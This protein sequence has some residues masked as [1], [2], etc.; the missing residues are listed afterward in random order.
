MQ[1]VNPLRNHTRIR[2]VLVIAVLLSFS[3]SQASPPDCRWNT[4]DVP[5]NG[6]SAS[7]PKCQGAPICDGNESFT[8]FSGQK[9]WTMHQVAD[10]TGCYAKQGDVE[11]RICYRVYDCERVRVLE[12]NCHAEHG[13]CSIQD[14]TRICYY[15]TAGAELPGQ[16]SIYTVEFISTPNPCNCGS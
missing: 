7:C 11:Q 6:V 12:R 9:V 16:A 15:C 2:N 1:R 10:G 8:V 3:A 13:I 4:Q 5:C 14:E